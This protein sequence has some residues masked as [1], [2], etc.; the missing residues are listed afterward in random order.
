MFERRVKQ[1]MKVVCLVTVG[2]LIYTQGIQAKRFKS[3]KES[4]PECSQYLDRLAEIDDEMLKLRLERKE[5]HQKYQE[6]Y[7]ARDKGKDVKTD[8]DDVE[9]EKPEKERPEKGKKGKKG[10]GKK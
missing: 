2:L 8:T 3:Q 5:L 6:C 9:K 4:P 1:F 7:K 10:K